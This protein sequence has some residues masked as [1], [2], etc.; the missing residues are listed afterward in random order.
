MATIDYL[1]YFP[2]SILNR[3]PSSN[4]GKLWNLFSVQVDL[5]LAEVAKGCLLYIISSQSGYNLDQ[6]GTLIQQPRKSAESDEDY[7]ISMYAAIKSRISSGSIPD[8]LDVV[9][10]VKAGDLTLLAKIIEVYPAKIQVYTNMADLLSNDKK[11]L[12]ESRAAGVGLLLNYA[13]GVNPLV[14]AGDSG[15]SGLSSSSSSFNE[16]GEIVSIIS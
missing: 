12:N 1:Q 15:G 4:L 16:G 7:R 6:I 9:E 2:V 5:L 14:L 11:I 3:D 13:T 8:L 10:V